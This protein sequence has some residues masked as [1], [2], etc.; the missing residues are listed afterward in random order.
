MKLEIAAGYSRTPD[1]D[2]YVD[3]NPNCNPDVV[4]DAISLPFGDNSFDAVRCVD[5][6]EHMSY[7]VTHVALAEW[8]RVL[9]PGGEIYIQV[10]DVRMA[11]EDWLAGKDREGFRPQVVPEFAH[12]PS[13]VSLAWRLLGGHDTTSHVTEG[14]DW[15]WNAHYALFDADSLTWYMNNAGL[16]ITR[17]ETNFHP[18]LLCWATKDHP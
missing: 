15:R 14:D 10:P 1:F 4:S 9:K 18:N 3:I 17:L 11:I 8:A 16:R 5:I 13:I 12:L 6:L 7:S 2:I